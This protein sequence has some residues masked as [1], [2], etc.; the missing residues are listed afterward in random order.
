MQ[1]KYIFPFFLGLSAPVPSPSP[2]RPSKNRQTK[3]ALLFSLSPIPFAMTSITPTP[4]SAAPQLNCLTFGNPV[5]SHTISPT[6]ATYQMRHKLRHCRLVSTSH[7]VPPC[8]FIDIPQRY[9]LTQVFP[10]CTSRRIC[11]LHNLDSGYT[12]PPTLPSSISAG[13]YG[14]LC[15]KQCF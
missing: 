8:M 10:F 3:L 1:F 13:A 14:S 9:F 5:S 11:N 7:S 4:S 6:S 2:S 12:P 15:Y